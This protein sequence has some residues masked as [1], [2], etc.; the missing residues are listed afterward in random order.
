[1][2]YRPL[3]SVPLKPGFISFGLPREAFAGEDVGL[4]ERPFDAVLDG[5]NEFPDCIWLFRGED[6]LRFNVKTGQFEDGPKPLSEF[7]T[8]LLWPALFNQVD[9]ASWG[10]RL[11]PHLQYFFHGSYFIKA[12]TNWTDPYQPPPFPLAE[13]AWGP[14]SDDPFATGIDAAIHG[15]GEE[16]HCIHFFKKNLYWR[17]NLP[18]GKMDRGPVEISSVWPLPAYFTTE[19]D[20]VFYGSGDRDAT[21]MYFVKG[22]EYVRY[23]TRTRIADAA[24]PLERRFPPFAQY[25][26]RPQ[27][28]VVEHY[29][30]ER[31]VGSITLGEEVGDS[32][33]TLSGSVRKIRSIVETTIVLTQSS[34][35]TILTSQESAV[36][37]NFYDEARASNEAET[38]TDSYRY[39]MDAS[40]HGEASANSAW[41]GEVDAQVGA[42]GDTNEVRDRFAT[43]TNKAATKQVTNAARN[44]VHRT[45]AAEDVYERTERTLRESIITIDRTNKPNCKTRFHAVLEPYLTFL[46]LQNVQLAYSDGEGTTRLFELDQMDEMLNEYLSNVD[47]ITNQSTVKEWLLEQL[48][49]V[50]NYL[51]EKVSVVAVGQDGSVRFKAAST[52]F[53]ITNSD[54][55]VETVTVPGLIIRASSFRIGKNQIESVTTEFP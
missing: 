51:G 29:S 11:F 41:G 25:I 7:S 34:L 49:S 18:A 46:T 26:P 35:Q 37:K 20:S 33:E 36:M 2:A 24:K 28:F 13:G 31:F 9:A 4:R 50:R 3:V 47:D 14:G 44:V 32:V 43:A 15:L 16:T 52:P 30:I 19:L 53:N 10:G 27:F 23:N 48:T 17:H 42:Q 1:M 22:S 8:K 6:F 21:S 40:F 55:T 54:G 5:G 38:A 12:Q 45:Q 39:R